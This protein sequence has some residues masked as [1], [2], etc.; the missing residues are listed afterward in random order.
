M[1]VSDEAALELF[2]SK[3]AE[4]YRVHIERGYPADLN[5]LGQFLL[6]QSD[7]AF[8]R[9]A[10]LV[11]FL[12]LDAAMKLVNAENLT[13]W[14]RVCRVWVVGAAV[15]AIPRMI[16]VL[17]HERLLVEY[18]FVVSAFPFEEA[19]RAPRLG[20]GVHGA[21]NTNRNSSF[22]ELAR[23]YGVGMRRDWFSR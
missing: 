2:C 7:V 15:G 22:I 23:T 9:I 12:L 4:T 14:R 10:G 21:G 16:E 19:H 20:H 5:D 3:V 11:S 6:P 13:R 8:E 17:Q 18:G 1:V